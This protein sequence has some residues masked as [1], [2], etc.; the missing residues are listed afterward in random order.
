[1]AKDVLSDKLIALS[2]SIRLKEWKWMSW[3]SNSRHWKR[4]KIDR[5]Q[6]K[7]GDKVTAMY[8]QKLMLEYTTEMIDLKIGQ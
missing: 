1:M 6:R 7:T 2:P 8:K 4:N 3:T 5:K